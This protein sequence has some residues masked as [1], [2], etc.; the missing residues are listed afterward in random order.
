MGE[1]EIATIGF[2][3]YNKALESVDANVTLYESEAEMIS[4]L[5]FRLMHGFALPDLVIAVAGVDF[6]IYEALLE[7]LASRSL[8]IPV[9]IY[10]QDMNKERKTWASKLGAKDYISEPISDEE[11]EEKIHQSLEEIASRYLY[12]LANSSRA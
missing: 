2:S 8:N 6:P 12:E 10:D 3:P 4:G 5:E 11:F 9:I 7:Y 1:R